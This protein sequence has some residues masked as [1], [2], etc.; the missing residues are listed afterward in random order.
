MTSGKKAKAIPAK[1]EQTETILAMTAKMYGTYYKKLLESGV[2]ED[3][4]KTLVQDLH[5][6]F[7]ATIFS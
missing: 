1:V 4:A 6:S 2:P 7:N 5:S 3:L